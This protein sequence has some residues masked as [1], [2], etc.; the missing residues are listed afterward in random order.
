MI[1]QHP[2]PIS[3]PLHAMFPS[4]YTLETNSLQMISARSVN[5]FPSM[6]AIAEKSWEIESHF[7]RK[8]SRNSSNW[9]TQCQLQKT[10]SLASTKKNKSEENT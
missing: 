2:M 5:P 3:T 4:S 8:S 6:L 1:T 9:C 7:S 10:A